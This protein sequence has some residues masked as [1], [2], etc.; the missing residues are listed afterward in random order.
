MDIT[1]L[2]FRRA[3]TVV[4]GGLVCSLSGWAQQSPRATPVAETEPVLELTPFEVNASADDGYRVTNALSGTRFNTNLLD[5]PKAVDVVSSEFMKDIGAIDLASAMQYTAGVNQD[6]PPGADDITGGRFT[7]RGF[8]SDTRYRNGYAT[9]F[10]VDPILLERIEIIKGPSSVFSGPIEPGG[11]LNYITR[12]PPAQRTTNLNLRY[13]S[14]DRYRAQIVDGGPINRA[15]TLSYRVAGVYED[16]GSYQDFARRERYVLAGTLLWRPNRRTTVQTDLQYID[17]R[18]VPAADV[19]YFNTK[20]V[21][22]V[23]QYYF[24]PNVP[25]SFN[26]MGPNTKSDLVQFSAITDVTYVFNSTWSVRAGLLYSYQ[27]L[28]RLLIGG[29]TKVSVNATTGVR[30]VVRTDASYEPNAVS[31]VASPQVY[32]LGDF[33]YAGIGHKLIVGAEL[34]YNDQRNDVY[35]RA[36]KFPD[37]NIDRGTNN[38]Y[39]V[40]NPF[41]RNEYKPSDLRRVLNRHTGGSM[42][43]VFTLFDGRMTAM[44]ALRYSTVDTIRKNLMGAGTR[45]ATDQDNLVQSYGV[46]YRVLPR[47]TAFVSYSESFIPQSVFSFDGNILEPI[48]GSG[49][50]YGL[51]FDLLAGRLSGT[52]VGYD[53]TRENAPF[54]DPNHAG[55]YLATGETASQGVEVS[56]QVRPLE[57]WQIAASYSYI[58][59]EVVKDSSA[60]R[61]GRA[62]NI[63]DHQFSIWNNYRFKDGVL[64]GVGAGVGVIRVGNRRGN[65]SLPDQ[66]AINAEAYTKVDAYVSY[67]RKIFGRA[68]DFRL[69]AN[70]L[71]DEEYLV[72]YTGYGM[73]RTIAG[74]IG[75]RF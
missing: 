31:H 34:Y 11:T 5:L 6:G 52:V 69:E 50:D 27:D 30:T 74:S 15:K 51:K 75:V 32:L 61:L 13:E 47:L 39:T 17:N 59:A 60:V 73:P 64:K 28:E 18:I 72:S 23:V 12:R 65:P 49:W 40:G 22:G 41:D 33:K 70:N 14:Y 2:C 58:D 57:D 45:V 66:R 71:T 26:R 10:I 62:A 68:W 42:N 35:R 3:L 46:S 4:V 9:S 53:I 37:V 44:Q 63:P 48:K 8:S 21:G 38:D 24:E 16:F 36:T 29:S 25:H 19:P 43:N 7:V 67:A 55:F 1:P 20:T 56:L 54:T